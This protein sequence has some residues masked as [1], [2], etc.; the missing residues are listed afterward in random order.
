MAW[1]ELNRKEKEYSVNDMDFLVTAISYRIDAPGHEN[2]NKFFVE[3]SEL[4]LTNGGVCPYACELSDSEPN[5]DEWIN[6]AINL[7]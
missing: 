5:L 6:K 1:V 7:N 2:H 3:V 4:D